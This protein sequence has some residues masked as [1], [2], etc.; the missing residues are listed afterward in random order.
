MSNDS[1]DGWAKLDVASKAIGSILIPL[2]LF[3]ASQRIASQQKENENKR[4]EQQRIAQDSQRMADRATQLLKSL[5][6]RDTVERDLAMTVA[7]YFGQQR[8]LP[9][10][11]IPAMLQVIQRAQPAVGREEPRPLPAVTRALAA[12]EPAGATAGRPAAWVYLGA[13]SHADGKL[14]SRNFAGPDRITPPAELVASTAV[15]KR[16]APPRYLADEWRRGEVVGVVEEGQK[17][18]V[19]QVDTIPGTSNRALIWLKVDD[20]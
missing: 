2:A 12:V 16:A 1:R 18:R 4:S 5:A 15:L 3:V 14:V 11:L 9:R 8:Q 17:V 10:E 13:Y 19:T 20:R 6:S 7:T